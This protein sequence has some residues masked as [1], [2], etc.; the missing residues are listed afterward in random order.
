[1]ILKVKPVGYVWTKCYIV[2]CPQTRE[3]LIIDPG[4]EPEEI[5][6]EVEKE[7]LKIVYIVN[8]HGHIDHIG[9]NKAVKEATGAPVL[10]HREDAPYLSDPEKNLSLFLGLKDKEISPA[11]GLLEEGDVISVGTLKFKVLHTPGHTP[12]SICLVGEE[13]IFTGDTLF[14]G[15]IG[16][17]DFPGGSREQLL[18]SIK[19][20]IMPLPD[21][22]KAYP[23]HGP[24][25]TLRHEKETN[26]FLKDGGVEL[27]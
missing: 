13:V 21:R 27:D 22:L 1:M 4:D 7:G 3:G 15:S 23:G 12:G 9:A 6:A 18:R 16:R 19:E 8:T 10:I 20:K 2:G 26:P 14:A 25:S 17:T 24:A 5:L 11:D